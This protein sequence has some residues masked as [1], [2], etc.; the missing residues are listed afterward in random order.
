MLLPLNGSHDSKKKK[1]LVKLAI[2]LNNFLTFSK[3]SEGPV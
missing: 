2:D 1:K 3:P